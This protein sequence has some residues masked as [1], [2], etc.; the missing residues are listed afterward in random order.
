MYEKGEWADGPGI[1]DTAVTI[2]VLWTSK[3]VYNTCYDI[4]VV[5]TRQGDAGMTDAQQREAARQFYY[6]WNGKGREDEHSHIYWLELLQDVLGVED[7]TQRI[8]FE[9]KVVGSKGT[10]ER[11]DVYIP[12]TRVIIEQIH[13][14]L[15]R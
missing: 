9:K 2:R 5:C 7:V 1:T 6:R 15:S 8:S 14:S 12:E 3:T 4:H 11:I 13:G 10:V